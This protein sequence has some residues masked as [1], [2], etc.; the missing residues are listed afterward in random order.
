ME[1]KT[2]SE[3]EQKNAK[4]VVS[5][6][7]SSVKSE[8]K[9]TVNDF[10]K[11]MKDVNVKSDAKKTSGFISSFLTDPIGKI[12]EISS[13]VKHK[14]F[15]IAIILLILWSVVVLISSIGAQNWKFVNTGRNILSVIKDILSPVL[16]VIAFSMVVYFMQKGSVKKSLTTIITAIT[17]AQIPIIFAR[18]L[19]LINLFSNSAY[20]ILNP[21][22]IFATVISII[23]TYFTV[24][25]LFNEED[26]NKFIKSF[27]C[28]EAVY[29][30]VYFVV[31]FLE[32]YLYLL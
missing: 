18:V 29:Y 3:N 16:S 25:S 10:K 8:T 21:F 12:K 15:K 32:I 23:F 14:N 6:V 27:V 11:T 9:T 22:A 19:N 17:T 28:V 4:E 26:D 7:A 5:E 13:D 24:K 20:K 1:E 31:S 30:I 2:N